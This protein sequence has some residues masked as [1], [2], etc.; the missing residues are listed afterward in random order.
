[1]ITD[2]ISSLTPDSPWADLPGLVISFT[3]TGMSRPDTQFSREHLPRLEREFKAAGFYLSSRWKDC[4]VVGG[5]AG[6]QVFE[7]KEF[8]LEDEESPLRRLAR[9]LDTVAPPLD[10]SE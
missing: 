2:T 10:G 1:L 6:D 8:K 3:G 9:L 5:D 7:W 4:H